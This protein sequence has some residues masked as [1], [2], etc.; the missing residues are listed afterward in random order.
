MIEY[1]LLNDQS[2][3]IRRSIC[4]IDDTKATFQIVELDAWKRHCRVTHE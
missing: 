2:Y 4:I 3:R 1:V